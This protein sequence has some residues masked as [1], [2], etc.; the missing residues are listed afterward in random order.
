MEHSNYS[1]ERFGK[2]LD[3]SLLTFPEKLWELVNDHSCEEI[4]WS[5]DGKS[6]VVPSIQNFISEVL[7]NPKKPI[8]KTKNFSSFVRQLNLYGFRKISKESSRKVGKTMYSSKCEFKHP[9]FIEGKRGKL[10]PNRFKFFAKD[11]FNTDN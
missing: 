6:I 7:N 11:F 1:L 3:M 10:S 9:R 4:S 8:F 5:H 2:S